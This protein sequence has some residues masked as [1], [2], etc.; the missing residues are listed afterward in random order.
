MRARAAEAHARGTRADGAR[1]ADDGQPARQS[2]RAIVVGAGPA[3]AAAALA[4]AKTRQWDVRVFERRREAWEAS[5]YPESWNVTLTQRAFKAL[6]EVG[7]D[8]EA[9]RDEGSRLQSRVVLGLAGDAPT[10]A[11][12]LF[13]NL[14]LATWR[15]AKPL[16]AEARREGVDF[17]FGCECLGVRERGRGASP[18]ARFLLGECDDDGTQHHHVVEE[19]EADLVVAADGAS[20]SVRASLMRSAFGFD[21]SQ[22]FGGSME[23]RS[24]TV[25]IPAYAKL[26]S[27]CKA[28][29]GVDASTGLLKKVG[30]GLYN[31]FVPKGGVIVSPNRDLSANIVVT[32]SL[33]NGATEP[34]EVRRLILEAAPAVAALLT[35]Q[36]V[37]ALAERRPIAGK[38]VCLSR[39]SNG[40]VVLIGDA[41]HCMLNNLGQGANSAL[42]DVSL[43]MAQLKGTERVEDIA[44]ALTR[45]SSARKQDM[46][47]A[48]VL[49]KV[50]FQVVPWL[51]RKANSVLYLVIYRACQLLP[52]VTPWQTIVAQRV[53]VS[54]S[55]VARLRTLQNNVGLAILLLVGA[56][57]AA[58]FATVIR[59]AF[60]P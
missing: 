41:A 44:P 46:D 18:C 26:G 10:V 14:N 25:A 45:F 56:A 38:T 53:D 13:D 52:V 12:M 30:C 17:T 29:E 59:F 55:A 33:L 34:G 42:E 16:V 60:F 57:A 37:A 47:A 50:S 9:L 3:G 43:L 40:G 32:E 51:P 19:Y 24:T 58:L 54:Y 6:E 48:A 4:L 1:R 27:D 28:E 36:A 8:V 39:Y 20:S 31:A 5:A 22:D 23:F 11:P 15:I 2:M 7:I 35:D 21:V 49:S